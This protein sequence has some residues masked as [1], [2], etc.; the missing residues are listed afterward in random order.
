MR[1][2]FASL[3]VASA[4][5]A[6]PTPEQLEFFERSVRPVLADHCYKCH[7]PEKQ[8]GEL[9]LDSRTA[10]L[11]GADTGPVVVGSDP[12]KS[13]LITSVRHEIDSK[14]PDKAPKLSDAKIAALAEWVK[15]GLPWPENDKPA[16]P[17]MTR[18]SNSC[19]NMGT[20]SITS[21]GVCSRT[22][23]IVG[24]ASLSQIE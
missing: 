19:C 2:L 8:K 9:R 5:C 24:A 23:L 6:A 18:C 15:M 20:C 13:S 4:A 3:L 10:I 14:M 17:S 11:K 12:A 21:S 1:P 22:T 7:G 16:G